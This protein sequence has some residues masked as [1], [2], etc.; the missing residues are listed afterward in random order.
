MASEVTGA[1]YQSLFSH[2]LPSF[3]SNASSPPLPR[4]QSQWAL[5]PVI[6]QATNPCMA[7]AKP[8]H[9]PGVTLWSLP[10]PSPHF[11]ATYCFDSGPICPK[12]H[13]SLSSQASPT[14][15]L[16]LCASLPHQTHPPHHGTFGSPLLAPSNLCQLISANSSQ[17]SL[18]AAPSSPLHFMSDSNLEQTPYLQT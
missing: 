7:S 18:S 13:C 16:L 3:K 17:Y 9:T 4:T 14:T 12:G 1:L 8:P 2:I 5:V 10:Q 11:L 6:S 15:F